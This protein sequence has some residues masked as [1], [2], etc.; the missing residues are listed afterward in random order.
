MGLRV[1]VVC[2]AGLG[3]GRWGVE[4]EAA[5]GGGVGRKQLGTETL[6]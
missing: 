3:A 1:L 6:L 4:D 2:L 5:E